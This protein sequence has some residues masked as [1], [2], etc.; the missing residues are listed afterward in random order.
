MRKTVCLF[1]IATFASTTARTADWPR[2]RGADR[3]G[4][5]DENIKGEWPEGGPKEIWRV[6]LGAGYSSPAVVGDRLYITGNVKS[7]DELRGFLYALDTASG[8]EIWSCDY[9]KEWSANYPLARTTPTVVGDR[10]FLVSGT[11]DA[12]CVSTDG[13]VAWRVNILERFNGKNLR[14]G[15][16]ESP[17]V[18]DNKVICHPGGPD[19]TVVALDI[20]TGETLWTAKGLSGGASYCSPVLLTLHGVRQV[21]THTDN[22]LVGLDTDSGAVLWKAPYRNSR[23]IQPNT[24]LLVRTDT[25]AVG[26]GYGHGTHMFRVSKDDGGAFSAE[27]IWENKDADNHFYGIVLH[28]GVLFSGGTRGGMCAIDPKTGKT[29]YRVDEMKSPSLVKTSD[30]LIGYGEKD[31]VVCLL[32]ANAEKHAIKGKFPVTYGEGQHWAHPVV[33]NGILYIRHGSVLVAYSVGTN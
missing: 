20:Q 12:V 9:G 24:P 29:L 21:V 23:G 28:E 26:C 14:W 19:A 32:E 15:F 30:R 6:T 25:I 22:H 31:G 16:A 33:A 18:Y 8:K 1:L 10:I 7:G 11:M 3:T 4:V 17:L 5:A 13:K 27:Q 2:W